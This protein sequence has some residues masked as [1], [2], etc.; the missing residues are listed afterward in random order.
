M[1][2]RHL[3]YYGY[4]PTVFYPKRSKNELYQVS[5]SVV[6]VGTSLNDSIYSLF[7]FIIYLIPSTSC[8][9]RRRFLSSRVSFGYHCEVL[10]S[11]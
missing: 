2:A 5:T 4:Q 11:I 1:A 9:F 6:A 10:P 7:S 3:S 8:I